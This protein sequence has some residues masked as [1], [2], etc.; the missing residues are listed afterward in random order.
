MVVSAHA[1]K[2]VQTDA[3]VE[4][5]A[6]PPA[7]VKVE[8]V[9]FSVVGGLDPKVARTELAGQLDALAHCLDDN[10]ARLP[11]AAKLELEYSIDSTGRVLGAEVEEKA[12]DAFADCL[13]FTLASEATFSPPKKRGLCIV[14][15][16]L[17]FSAIKKEHPLRPDAA[18][19]LHR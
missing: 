1:R 12:N 4:P 16:G 11:S 13:Q 15:A 10:A 18:G 8:I 3:T 5:E 9:S 14:R 7:P 6:R 19:H 17:R 2:P